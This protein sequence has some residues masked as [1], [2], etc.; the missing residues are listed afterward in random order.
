MTPIHN[1]KITQNMK[2]PTKMYMKMSKTELNDFF[3][4]GYPKLYKDRCFTAY[5]LDDF[6][7]GILEA[8]RLVRMD[9][10]RHTVD[11]MMFALAK[12]EHLEILTA[13]MEQ[14]I[15]ELEAKDEQESQEIAETEDKKENENDIEKGDEENGNLGT[16]E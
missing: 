14:L 3:S 6:K 13:D 8:N 4:I 7:R 2:N 5:S 10:N 16:E 11:L 9:E 1:K 15:K 12:I